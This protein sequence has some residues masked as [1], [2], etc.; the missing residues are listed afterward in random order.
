[1]CK[2]KCVVH[3][4]RDDGSIKDACLTIT[5]HCPLFIVVDS[6]SDKLIE[7]GILCGRRRR[8]R[9]WWSWSFTHA[10]WR[11]TYVQSTLTHTLTVTLISN[12]VVGE[13]ESE[14]ENPDFR[15]SFSRFYQ[16]VLPI[17]YNVFSHA[18]C[19]Y[20]VVDSIFVRS[21]VGT[22][23]FFGAKINVCLD[24]YWRRRMKKFVSP[25]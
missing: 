17:V 6:R 25:P 14:R 22:L 1:M 16:F 11:T 4:W 21:S 15:F 5:S 18:F 3:R 19:I 12:H 7:C 10:W 8:R 9:G 24:E 23:N 2:V 13:G 20:P